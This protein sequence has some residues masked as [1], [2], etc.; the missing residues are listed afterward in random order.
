MLML[1]ILPQPFFLSFSWVWQ[2]YVHQ[3]ALRSCA[4]VGISLSNKVYEVYNYLIT[5]GKYNTKH[6]HK[7]PIVCHQQGGGKQTYSPLFDPPPG[8]GHAVK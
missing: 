7:Q 4:G 3:Y 2:G 6:R 1:M 8:G 5:S